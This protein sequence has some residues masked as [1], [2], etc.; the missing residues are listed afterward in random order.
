[1]ANKVFLIIMIITLLVLSSCTS[2]T[3][4]TRL[5]DL[6]SNY[7]SLKVAD[8]DTNANI[9]EVKKSLEKYAT[10]ESVGALNDRLT[11]HVNQPL[12]DQAALIEAQQKQI[13]TMRTDLDTLKSELANYKAQVDSSITTPTQSESRLVVSVTKS[14]DTVDEI[15]EDTESTADFTVKMVNKTSVKI[16]GIVITGQI[17][18]SR[19]LDMADNYP[20]LKDSQNGTLLFDY[21]WDGDNI[22]EFEFSRSTGSP[23]VYLNPNETFTFH[24]QLVLR[25]DDD[26]DNTYKFTLE[27]IEYTVGE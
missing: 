5:K 9:T 23:T 18:C 20:V 7:K 4:E 21:E 12:P 26:Y 14:K 15:L 17:T 19:N 13:N 27:I 2:D 3:T 6:E 1:M 10:A 8:S 25:G 16:D 22:I 24:P 11:D